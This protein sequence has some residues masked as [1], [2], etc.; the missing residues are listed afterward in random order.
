M[1]I[2]SDNFFPKEMDLQDLQVLDEECTDYI[3]G[4]QMVEISRTVKL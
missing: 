2:N 3:K 4:L 1:I